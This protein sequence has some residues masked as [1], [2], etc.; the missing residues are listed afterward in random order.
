MRFVNATYSDTSTDKV[1][2]GICMVWNNQVVFIGQSDPDI[3]QWWFWQFEVDDED[4]NDI[5]LSTIMSDSRLENKYETRGYS[6][7]GFDSFAKCV[8]AAFD[9]WKVKKKYI[10]SF[11]Q[12]I[13]VKAHDENE[14]RELAEKMFG[15]WN[16]YIEEVG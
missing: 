14:A 10:V 9:G 6:E 8:K 1:Y 15:D 5:C 12:T 13:E 11:A 2:Q 16:C 4:N 3:G 7:C